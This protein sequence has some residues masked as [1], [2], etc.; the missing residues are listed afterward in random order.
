MKFEEEIHDLL[1]YIRS[2]PESAWFPIGTNRVRRMIPSFINVF[3][4]ISKQIRPS[5]F[6]S[7]GCPLRKG[8]AV[9]NTILHLKCETILLH[10]SAGKWWASSTIKR[11]KVFSFNLSMGW[12]FSFYHNGNLYIYCG[13]RFSLLF[14]LY[15]RFSVYFSNYRTYLIRSILH[16]KYIKYRWVISSFPLM[17]SYVF[18][19]I[20]IL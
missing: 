6:S 2:T 5:W 12:W 10:V 14:G 11:L 9:R 16:W 1:T 17:Q 13:N 20:W 18:F 3:R 4:L 19:I 8:V 15:I 7:M